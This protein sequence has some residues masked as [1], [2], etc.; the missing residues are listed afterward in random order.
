MSGFEGHREDRTET[1]RD[2]VHEWLGGEA[3]VPSHQRRE[4]WNF[5][6]VHGAP[7]NRVTWFLVFA[8]GLFIGSSAAAWLTFRYAAPRRRP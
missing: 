8:A 3:L 2:R 1:P 4:S 5:F 7:C 6:R